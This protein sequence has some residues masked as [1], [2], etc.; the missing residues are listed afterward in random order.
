MDLLSRRFAAALFAAVLLVGGVAL[1]QSDLIV[2]P[3]ARARPE[4]APATSKAVET[5][6]AGRADDGW[7]DAAPK[8]ASRQPAP[9]PRLR[10]APWPEAEPAATPPVTATAPAAPS[11]HRLHPT[12]WARVVPEIIDPWGPSRLAVYRDPLIVDPWAR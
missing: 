4:K 9:A 10:L 1:A 7:L 6:N 11:T 12:H 2:D 8:A 3:W 5:P